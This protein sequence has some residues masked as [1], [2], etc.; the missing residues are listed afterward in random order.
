MNE[1]KAK[2]Y[3]KRFITFIYDIIFFI[4]IFIY[5]IT[6]ILLHST[7]TVLLYDDVIITMHEHKFCHA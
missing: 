2:T 7:F 5:Y 3:S 4:I 1:L 6:T